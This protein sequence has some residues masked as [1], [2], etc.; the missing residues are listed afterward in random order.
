MRGLDLRPRKGLP[1][2][3]VVGG[4]SATKIGR[5]SSGVHFSDEGR[6]PAGD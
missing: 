6:G 3:L 1:S 5:R 2:P 4:P